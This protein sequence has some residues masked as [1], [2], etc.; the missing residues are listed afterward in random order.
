MRWKGREE[1]GREGGRER[2]SRRTFH[3]AD[4]NNLSCPSSGTNSKTP[5]FLNFG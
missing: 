2:E 4:V 5:K 1:G 3:L